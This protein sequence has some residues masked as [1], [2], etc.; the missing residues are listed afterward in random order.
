[1]ATKIADLCI[2]KMDV[3]FYAPTVSIVGGI[4]VWPCPSVC[5]FVCALPLLDACETRE[6]LMLG[7]GNFIHGMGTKTKRTCILLSSDLVLQSYARFLS[8]LCFILL[9]L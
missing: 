2:H 8:L 3:S 5:L 6:W 4:L 9:A 7:T 1:M